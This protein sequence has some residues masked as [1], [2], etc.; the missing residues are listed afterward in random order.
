MSIDQS[1]RV[2]DAPP[3]SLG[4]AAAERLAVGWQPL[5]LCCCLGMAFVYFDNLRIFHT[6]IWGHVSYGEWILEHGRLPTEEPL[7]DLAEGMPLYASAWLSQVVFAKVHQLG[8]AA[9]ISHVFALSMTAALLLF[10]LGLSQRTGGIVWG[11]GAALAIY[12]LAPTRIAVV[13]PETFGTLSFAAL[14]ALLVTVDR[15]LAN[16][17]TGLWN[18]VAGAAIALLFLLWANLHGSYVVGIAVLGARV[19]GD[20]VEAWTHGSVEARRTGQTAPVRTGLVSALRSPSFRYWLVVTELAVLATFV[21]PYGI[22]L[23]VNAFAF[24]SNPNLADVLEWQPLPLISIEGITFAASWVALL[25]VARFSRVRF[26]VHEVIVLAVL[27]LAV[28]KGVR[29]IYWYAAVYVFALAPHV[30]DV[31]SRALEWY[32]EHWATPRATQVEEA[33]EPTLLD[34]VRGRSLVHTMLCCLVLWWGFAFSPMGN[35]LMGGTPRTRDRLFH[36]WTPHDASRFLVE[37][38]VRGRVFN[39]QWWGDWFVREAPGPKY[40]MTTN[41]VHVVPQRVWR[42]YL[43]VARGQNGWEEVLLRYDVDRVVVHEEAQERLAEVLRSHEE[44]RV[45]YEDD[46]A[47]VFDRAAA[48]GAEARPEEKP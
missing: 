46:V 28:V 8:G 7:L 10:T 32:S 3:F 27:N 20:F 13:R 12:A 6:D 33:D 35:V 16:G 1:P 31:V 11:V 18:W 34:R 15:R 17:R 44:W 9:W 41:A 25:F 21:N 36:V 43:R 26:R 2:E 23:L 14:L 30:R 5:V 48:G 47:I 42:D 37:N 45:V 24:P 40:F 19:L 4:A 39:P 29:M 22:D 38:P